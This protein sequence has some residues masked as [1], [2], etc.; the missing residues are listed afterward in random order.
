MSDTNRPFL[1]VRYTLGPDLR[2]YMRSNEDLAA[3]MGTISEAIAAH[4]SG[5]GITSANGTVSILMF[6]RVKLITAY[7]AD[8][9]LSST[10]FGTIL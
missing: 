1:F 6:S 4:K 10:P 5:V 3:S 8:I 2:V 7:P 9:D